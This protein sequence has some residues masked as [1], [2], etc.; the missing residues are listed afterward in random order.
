MVTVRE[1]I[2]RVISYLRSD[3]RDCEFDQELASHVEMAT[4]DHL[5]EGLNAEDARRLALAKLGGVEPAK[6]LHRESCGLPSLDAFLQ[7]VRY[8]WRHCGA[9]PPSRR[10]PS[11]RSPSASGRRPRFSAR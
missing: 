3:A 5:R 9:S 8:G 10:R 1:A 4:S 11:R 7:D 6:Q 2:A